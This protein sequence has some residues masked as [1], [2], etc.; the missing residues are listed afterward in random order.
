MK[1]EPEKLKQVTVLYCEDETEL[2]AVTAGLLSRIV[3]RVLPAHDG[4]EGLRL[5]REHGHE[6]DMVI[7]DINMPKMDGLEMTRHI[8][9][10]MPRI[11]VIVTTAYSSTDHLFEAIDIH[12]DKYVLKP[13]DTKKLL[14]AMVQSLLYHELRNLYRDPLTNLPTRNALL[15]DLEAQKD[16]RLILVS[17]EHFAHIQD[18]YG[19]EIGGRVLTAFSQYL[20]AEF[21]EQ[22]KIYRIGYDNFVLS[23]QQLDRR[24]EGI[25]ESLEAFATQC[26]NEGLIVEEI[27]IHLIMTFAMAYSEDGHTLQ[28]VQKAMQRATK[29]HLSF[30][31]YNPKSNGN[32]SDY[33]TNIWWT[34]ELNRAVESDMFVPYFQPIV[35]TQTQ[36]VCKYEA[37]IRYQS[38]EGK[39]TG[40][41]AFLGI[42]KKTNL[43]PVIMRVVLQKV[44]EVI[45]RKKVRVAVNISY[46][47]LVNQDTVEFIETLLRQYPEEAR[48]I[49]FEILESEKIDNYQL[50]GDFIRS[51]KR[52][53]CLVGIDD[54]GTGYSNFGMVEALNMDYVK[55]NGLLIQGIH[56]SERQ[57]LI[58]ETIH[59]FCH[60][61]GI[62]TV[63]EMVSCEEEYAVVKR[64][65][66]DMTQGWY[67]S[68]E[69]DSDEIAD[70]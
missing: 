34:Q 40:P 56:E 39:L 48:L 15:H 64:I 43:Y 47:D 58:V 33:T 27:P 14:E 6:I 12:V 9:E 8:K 25:R 53:G 10:A 31:E 45:S 50:T 22:F 60:K 62:K 18:L 38:P 21:S 68:R 55:I 4:E 32:I 42:A 17:I 61:L 23:D 63:A 37:L 24:P 13:L 5:F 28:Y 65:G 16:N 7:T 35:D 26:K 69:I 30:I 59:S 52:H 51:A 49:E 70:A 54:F 19:E 41:I 36:E 46:I 44:I 2:H 67:F 11:P 29:N 3:K 1:I 66:V 57:A 20:H